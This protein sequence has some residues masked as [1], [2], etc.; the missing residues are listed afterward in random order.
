MQ[1]PSIFTRII[2]GEI[3]CH[4]IYEDEYSIA[5]LDIHPARP[6]H[7]LVV[8]KTQTDRLETLPE[9]DYMYLMGTVKKV[10]SR[11]VAI[12]GP[13]YRACL[14][15]EGFD[16]PHAHLHVI[17]CRKAADFWAK[18]DVLAEPD[19]LSLSDIAKKLAF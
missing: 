5:F 12:Y 1:E 8:P 17:P 3:P 15:L 6:G 4:K 7:T 2:R 13:E 11:I 9:Q 14:K 16:V 19:H 10:M 18:Q